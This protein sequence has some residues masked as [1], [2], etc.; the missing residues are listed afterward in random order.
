MNY[1][2][3]AL[4]VINVLISLKGFSD[5]SFFERYKFQ[6]GPILNGEQVR[7][8]T[9][10][11][12]HVD[13][14]HLFFNMFALYI[15]A[16]PVID[17]LG[18]FK[19]VII[20]LGSLLAGSTL[21]LSFHKK[22]PYYSAVGASGAVMGIIYAGIM[23]NP[24][25]RL[26]F[27]FFPFFDIPGYV[28]GVGYLLYSM[29]GM[30]KQLGNTGHSAHLGGAVGGFVLTLALFPEV[31]MQNK[32]ITIVLAIPIILMFVFKNKLENN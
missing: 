21:A 14:A 18:V 4:I 9:S 30:K 32:M 12:L 25:M 3:V 15:F 11:F 10:G 16:D 31:F 28:F 13:Q 20:Y 8:F 5:R 19:F 27:I 17:Q 24:D 23:L 2:V 26:T 29:Y 6:I 1:A 7:M 22:D